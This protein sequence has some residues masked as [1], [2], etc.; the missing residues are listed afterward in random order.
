M[1]LT[2]IPIHMKIGEKE[3]R[4]RSGVCAISGVCAT[5]LDLPKLQSLALGGA[6]FQQ[7]RHVALQN[8][9]ALT[10]IRLGKDALAFANNDASELVLQNMPELTSL[11]TLSS[12][13]SKSFVYPRVL[14]LQHMPKLETVTLS[15]SAFKHRTSVVKEDIGA[16]EKYFEES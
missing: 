10:S 8:L 13:D 3:L 16:L 14:D 6:A 11:M 7:S 5:T 15:P 9:P 4:G 2:L 12:G 1:F